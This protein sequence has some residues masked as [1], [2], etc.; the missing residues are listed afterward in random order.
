MRKHHKSDP[1]VLPLASPRCRGS[2][3]AA[4]DQDTNR[5]IRCVSN[6]RP[7]AAFLRG[8]GGHRP[9]DSGRGTG[10]SELGFSKRRGEKTD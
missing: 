4:G 10:L 1:F 6:T 2:G 5:S 8:A 3:M 7:H 9:P